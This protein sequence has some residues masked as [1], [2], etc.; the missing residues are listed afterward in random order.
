MEVS[1]Y[2]Q[3]PTALILGTRQRGDSVA[4]PGGPDAVM[5]RNNLYP[6][7]ESNLSS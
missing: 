2:L 4:P 5:K 6:L 1:N 7:R 3:A